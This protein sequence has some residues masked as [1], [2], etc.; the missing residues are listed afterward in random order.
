MPTLL[1]VIILLLFPLSVLP[2]PLS[3]KLYVLAFMFVTTAIIPATGIF[4]LYF[5]GSIEDLTLR[6]RKQR[7]YPNLLTSLIYA[8]V[9]FLLYD[10]LHFRGLLLNT[11]LGATVLVFLLSVVTLYWKISLH[12]AGIVGII[13]FLF[14]IHHV[15]PLDYT[16]E[17]IIFALIF[18][19]FVMSAR[20]YLGS[21]TASQIWAGALLGG[22]IGLIIPLF[23]L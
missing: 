6:D 12:S 14:G 11:M 2:V 15:L 7:A 22:V 23:F 20:L 1:Y 21:H 16:L 8:M 3:T 10:K 4:L 19:G 18:S 5:T 17:T 13:G 9:C